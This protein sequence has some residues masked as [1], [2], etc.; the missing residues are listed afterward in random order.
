VDL[1]GAMSRDDLR[2]GLDP[3]Y[4]PTGTV[5]ERPVTQRPKHDTVDGI[6]EWLGDLHSIFRRSVMSSMN[7]RGGCWRQ[8]FLY[9][10][11]PLSSAHFT[12]YT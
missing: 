5:V 1:N 2:V 11:R 9:Y 3:R 8:A 10:G 12:L 7:L 4:F 6:I